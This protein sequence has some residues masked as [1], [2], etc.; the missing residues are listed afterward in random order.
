MKDIIND[1]YE[2]LF[3]KKSKYI[4]NISFYDEYNP[5]IHK[6]LLKK[7][8]TENHVSFYTKYPNLLNRLFIGDIKVLKNIVS[9]EL[10]DIQIISDILLDIKPHITSV[11]L[12]KNLEEVFNRV[13]NSYL[14]ENQLLDDQYKTN[15][16]FISDFE[17]INYYLTLYDL[18]ILSLQLEIGFVLFTNR[19]TNKD[20]KFQTYKII[21]K[22]LIKLLKMN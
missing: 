17:D 2:Y 21:H 19:Y 5:R 12:R 7:D 22:D 15:D 11:L 13:E 8:F 20:T 14:Y 9:D 4:R 6:K 1:L 3:I 16:E 10:N 18:R